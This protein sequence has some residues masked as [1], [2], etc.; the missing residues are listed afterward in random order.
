MFV[1]VMK[2]INCKKF[3][4]HADIFLLGVKSGGIGAQLSLNLGE[5]GTISST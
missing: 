1:P 4:I 2:Y 3:M 5:S